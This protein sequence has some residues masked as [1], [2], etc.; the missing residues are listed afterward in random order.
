METY[1]YVLGGIIYMIISYT[2]LKMI[3]GVSKEFSDRSLSKWESRIYGN[4]VLSASIASIF[5][6]IIETSLIVLIIE[7]IKIIGFGFLLII[8]FIF[9]KELTVFCFEGKHKRVS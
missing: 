4:P 3:V 1:M 5:F 6:T 9:L 8:S 2:L 7:N